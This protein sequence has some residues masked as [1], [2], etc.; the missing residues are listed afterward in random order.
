VHTTRQMMRDHDEPNTY[1]MAQCI[2]SLPLLPYGSQQSAS[3]GHGHQLVVYP[4]Q[5]YQI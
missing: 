3:L 2:G 5:R 1:Q 4:N